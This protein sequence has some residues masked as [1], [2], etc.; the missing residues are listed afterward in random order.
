LPD[1]LSD[2]HWQQI[3]LAVTQAA[4]LYWVK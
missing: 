2:G 1:A 4:S 3:T